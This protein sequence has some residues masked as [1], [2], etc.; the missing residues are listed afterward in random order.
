MRVTWDDRLD[1]DLTA[2]AT[3]ADLVTYLASVGEGPA[4]AWCGATRLDADHRAGVPPL[5]HGASLR[6][7]AGAPDP[8]LSD[9]HLAVVCGPDAGAMVPLT[10]TG[11]SIGRDP[12]CD[13]ALADDAVSSRHARAGQDTA[14][15]VRDE[16]SRNGTALM[17]A[18]GT[19]RRAR[20]V[21][22]RAGDRLLLGTTVL[23]LRPLPDGGDSPKSGL[24]RLSGSQLGAM[25]AGAMT[26]IMLAVMTGRWY[27]ALLALA[28]PVMTGAPVIAQRLRGGAGLHAQDSGAPPDDPCPR[29]QAPGSPPRATLVGPIAVVGETTRALATA[30][31]LVLAQR[32]RP[33]DDSWTEPWM[34]WL[35]PGSQQ[36]SVMV[37]PAGDAA[38]SW[39]TTVVHALADRTEVRSGTSTHVAARCW[40]REDTA[41]A[42]ARLL[43]AQRAADTLPRDV[44][45]ADLQTTGGASASRPA[46]AGGP[47]GRVIA[48]PIGLSAHGP[49]TMDLDVHGPHLVVAGTTGAGKSAL[50]ETLVLGLAHTYSPADLAI[51]LIDF[52]GGSGLRHCTGLPHV[53]GCLTDL[54]PHLAE[55]ALT[56]IGAELELRKRLVSDAGHGSLR[57]WE[58]SGGAPPRLLVVADEY[59]E[60][61]QHHRAF[62]PH[63]ARLAAQG[64]SLGLHLILATQRPAG[65]V[66]P[67]IR[68][69]VTTTIALRVASPAE[70]QDLLGTA[71]AATI[72]VDRPGRAILAHGTNHQSIQIAR[73]TATAT[74]PVRPAGQTS[75]SAPAEL[76]EAAAARW[77]GVAVPARLWREPL[78]DRLPLP[79][80]AGSSLALTIGLADWPAARRQHLVSWNPTHGPI[81]VIGPRGSGRTSLLRTLASQAST[82]GL[83]PV[84][85]PADA[86]EAA[87]TLALVADREDVLLL[88]DDAADAL[89]ALVDCDQGA[90]ADVLARRL[91]RGLPAGL[92]LATHDPARLAAS[93]GT[94]IVLT[95]ADAADDSL[96][97]VPRALAGR[98]A[99]PGRGRLGARGEWCEVQLCVT[100][101]PEISAVSLVAPLPSG[102]DVRLRCTQ[103]PR[104]LAVGGDG[105]RDIY[106]DTGAVTVV[107]APSGERDAIVAH[108]EGLLGAARRADLTVR[109]DLLGFPG[110]PRPAGTIVAVRPTVRSVRDACGSVHIGVVDR[111]PRAGRV[112]IVTD[113]GVHAAQLPVTEHGESGL[114]RP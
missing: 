11:I 104:L 60:I 109:D 49:V 29:A 64:R 70:S 57:E 31:G 114:P 10:R 42:L 106:L 43:A 45:W 55:R 27:F 58:E 77:S 14:A 39:A 52:K 20:R 67:E 71:A 74:P 32:V 3:C 46:T 59:Q 68:A 15:W 33:H 87:R 91:A 28:Y 8:N 41:D 61:A 30:R 72:P 26:G 93:A 102:T 94:R 113:A 1:L 99:V 76:A 83:L 100:E 40:V 17:R 96:W 24:P 111:V 112:V 90:P 21:L 22:P 23:E 75:Q 86:R 38:P 98:P 73:P 4:Q 35:P 79:R 97:N 34:R 5:V 69:N 81:A 63:L 107:G 103:D 36:Q 56:A 7:S 54:D 44:A 37:V 108:V 19:R 82:A 51:A 78:P 62:L 89:A 80:A 48:T 65:A 105:A 47:G 66:T 85:L 92:A 110:A 16:G 84:W 50:L 9:P 2:A 101:A 6:P 53:V 18:D 13:L 12:S 95:G 88:I 25:G